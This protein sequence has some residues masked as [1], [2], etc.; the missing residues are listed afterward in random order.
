MIDERSAERMTDEC[1]ALDLESIERFA[2]VLNERIDRVVIGALRFVGKPV[3]LEIDGDGANSGG[4]EGRHV[5]P[6]YVRAAAPAVH[7][8]DRR[9]IRIAAFNCANS[10]S[11]LEPRK[12]NPICRISGWKHLAGSENAAATKP[13]HRRGRWIR[14]IRFLC[15]EACR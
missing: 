14:S 9:R 3:S 2:Q 12:T 10:D 15:R 6:E 5:E 8:D 11:R 13:D 7:H 4:R 1:R